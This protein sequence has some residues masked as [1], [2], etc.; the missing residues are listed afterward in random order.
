MEKFYR[1]TEQ[2]AASG[3]ITS[4]TIKENRYL[5]LA[6][7][8]CDY[9]YR[10]STISDLAATYGD[11][12]SEWPEEAIEAAEIILKHGTVFEING[13]FFAPSDAISEL[14]W[15][16]DVHG[17]DRRTF[18]REEITFDQYCAA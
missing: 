1:I 15:A 17:H 11:D 14:E 10:E 18:K 13:E 3:K 6:H 16:D 9:D 2:S 12:R 7:N 5:E 8:E 4:Y